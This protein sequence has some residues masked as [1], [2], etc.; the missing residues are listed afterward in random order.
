METLM[1]ASVHHR[2]T[3]VGGVDIFYRE[4]GP[5]D[6]PVVLLPHGYPCSSYEFRNYMRQVGDH[7]RLLA[8]DFPGSGYSG[9]PQGF[10]YNF[11]GFSVFLEDFAR[12]LGVSRFA[13]YLHDFGS[14]IGLRLAMCDPSRVVALIIQNG[15]I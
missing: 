8:P 3:T 6:A 14:W 5:A 10:A 7:W 15:D 9:T 4:A 13:I 2:R 11:D 12:T 1:L